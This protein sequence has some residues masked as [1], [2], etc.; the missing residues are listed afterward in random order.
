ML[1]CTIS[2]FRFDRVSL[3]GGAYL[4]LFLPTFSLENTFL[5]TI[6]SKAVLCLHFLSEECL[7][8]CSSF[9]KRLGKVVWRR[10]SQFLKYVEN[11]L[12]NP[13]LRLIQR[14]RCRLCSLELISQ[15]QLVMEQY[16]SLTTNQHQLKLR[17]AEQSSR[18]WDKSK[19]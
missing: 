19:C 16:F 4:L 5:R 13:L 6:Q 18:C 14:K 12:S 17:P 11:L 15:N 8:F 7:S 1:Q 9:I 3:R 2:C 10:Q